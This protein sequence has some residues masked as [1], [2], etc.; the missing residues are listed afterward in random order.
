MASTVVAMDRAGIDHGRRDSTTLRCIHFEG[1]VNFRD[2]GGY[3]TASRGITRWGRVFRSD[4]LHRLTADDLVVYERLGIHTVYDLRHE[5]ERRLRPNPMM[6][7][8]IELER[9]VPRKEFDDGSFLETAA[10]AERRLR[11]VYLA[12]LATAA[13]LFGELFSNLV[14]PGG[15]P[16]L[17]HCAGG[18]DRTGLVA[19]L[20]LTLLG[21]DRETVLDDYELTTR[22]QRVER[23]R[24][25]LE[26]FVASGMAVEAAT[27]LLATPRWIMAEALAVLDQEH[28][29][30]EGYLT[31]PGAMSRATLRALRRLLVG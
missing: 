2:L 25:I 19:A 24:E 26:G 12:I 10:D 22:L 30:V 28:G 9:F 3:H 5:E 20:L 18:K 23:H 1:V 4:G 15:L 8:S 29:G 21:V 27:A 6:S 14:E 7:R 31:G 17:F 16:A 11:D 13:P